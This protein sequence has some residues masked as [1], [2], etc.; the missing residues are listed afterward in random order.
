MRLVAIDQHQLQAQTGKAFG[1]CQAD[2]GRC[3][4]NQGKIA[5]LQ[6]RVDHD[7]L[8]QLIRDIGARTETVKRRYYSMVSCVRNNSMY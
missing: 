1:R 8:L 5:G 2:A 4:G 6:S 7:G 3:A